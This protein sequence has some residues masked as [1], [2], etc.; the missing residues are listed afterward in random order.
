MPLEPTHGLPC[1]IPEVDAGWA[2]TE[3]PAGAH[4]TKLQ[5]VATATG[6]IRL[7]HRPASLASMSKIPLLVRSAGGDSIIPALVEGQ[8]PA[9][10]ARHSRT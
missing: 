6:K 8:A 9:A 7:R 3:V 2:P 5:M 1:T 4:R 10:P